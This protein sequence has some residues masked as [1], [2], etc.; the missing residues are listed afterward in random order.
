MSRAMMIMGRDLH[1][2]Y[3]QVAMLDMDTGEL[4]GWYQDLKTLSLECLRQC[5]RNTRGRSRSSIASRLV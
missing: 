4:V 1:T 5:S 3:Q 2:R